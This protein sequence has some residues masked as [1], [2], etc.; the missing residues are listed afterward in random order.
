MVWPSAFLR[1]QYNRALRYVVARVAEATTGVHAG[2]GIEILKN[3]AFGPDEVA[4]MPDGGV[5][6]EKVLRFRSRV[7][8]MLRRF[9]PLSAT[10]IHECSWFS[11]SKGSRC[12][13]IYRNPFLGDRFY[14][15][16][17]SNHIEGVDN[18]AN[19]VSLEPDDLAK[20]EVF[21]LD[22][23][24]NMPRKLPTEDPSTFISEKCPR[25]LLQPGWWKLKPAEDEDEG[26]LVTCTE[27]SAGDGPRSSGDSGGDSSRMEDGGGN[28]S[29][30]EDCGEEC[31]STPDIDGECNPAQ[32]SGGECISA[33]DSGVDAPC[34]EASSGEGACIP[35]PGDE[36]ASA[37][38]NAEGSACTPDHGASGASTPNTGLCNPGTS[39]DGSKPQKCR[40]P[41]EDLQP[42]EFFKGGGANPKHTMCCYKV[43]KMEFTGFGLRRF[44]QRWA[45]RGL[46]PNG[47]IDIHR[48]LF[49]WM[50]DW[51]DLTMGDIEKI[52]ARVAQNVNA[53]FSDPDLARKLAKKPAPKYAEEEVHL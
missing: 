19:A 1:A 52:E 30:V 10:E 32:D 4:G 31:N 51:W 36:G 5:Y 20:R 48:K 27:G 16:I 9:M 42:T 21:Y 44:I 34:P 7:P 25:G 43:V 29:R 37:P 35:E 39:A 53:V 50:D 23:A 26:D 14:L 3:E 18:A 11:S 38:F 17:D 24:G 28:G 40:R 13:T 45:T 49:V 22:I 46:I 6:T 33:P 47:F 8:A 41:D 12:R 2:E 15:S